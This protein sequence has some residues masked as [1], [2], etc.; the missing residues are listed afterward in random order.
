MATAQGHEEEH[1]GTPGMYWI[2][3]GYSLVFL[4]LYLYFFADMASKWPTS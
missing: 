4:L 1:E 2:S 3:A